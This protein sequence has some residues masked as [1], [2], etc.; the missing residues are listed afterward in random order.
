MTY[1]EAEKLA[2]IIET[3][4]RNCDTC[5]RDFCDKLNAV[6]H[7]FHFKVIDEGQVKVVVQI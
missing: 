7:I 3:I 1:E 5:I 6:F 2:E 4:D